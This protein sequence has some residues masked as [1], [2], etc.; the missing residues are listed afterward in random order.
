M[1]L[2]ICECKTIITF[3]KQTITISS[4]FELKPLL[5]YDIRVFV[6]NNPGKNYEVHFKT[7]IQADETF[8][9]QYK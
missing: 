2:K 1:F 5:V 9:F 6:A 4:G 7:Q 8:T 3:K